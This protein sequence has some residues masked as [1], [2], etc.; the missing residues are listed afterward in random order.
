MK[1]LRVD[2]SE[3]ALAFTTDEMSGMDHFLDLETGN[4]L[5]TTEDDRRAA[6]EF[7]EEAEIKEGEDVNARFEK[8]LEEYDCPDWQTDS[9]RDAFLIEREFGGRF[10]GVPKQES[11]DGYRDMV[12]FAESVTD[13]RLRDLLSV[14]LNGK[15][16]FRRFKDVL[17][18]YPEEKQ[19][20]YDFSEKQVNER[21]LEWLE[22]EDI[23]VEE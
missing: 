4:V 13:D 17:Y 3:L 10:I 12:D 20:W 19:R 22:S 1:K 5:M 14:A 18:S 23:E 11:R 9:I 7:F 2:L 15:G 8:W 21:V 6:E 16:A